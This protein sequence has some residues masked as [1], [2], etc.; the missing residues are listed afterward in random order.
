[1]NVVNNQ[2]FWHAARDLNVAHNLLSFKVYSQDLDRW[3]ISV[4]RVH[5]PNLVSIIS[6]KIAGNIKIAEELLPQYGLALR[7]NTVY[8]Y[9]IFRSNAGQ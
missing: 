9:C 3:L 4:I 5:Y 6:W 7:K 8:Y 2:E 1:M